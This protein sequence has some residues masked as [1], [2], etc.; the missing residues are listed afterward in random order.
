M[1]QMFIFFV[2]LIQSGASPLMI[3][4][5]C[6]ML[7]VVQALL[8]FH[9]RVDVFDEV[10]EAHFATKIIQNLSAMNK[11]FDFPVYMNHD[12]LSRIIKDS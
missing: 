11:Y 7:E 5:Q 4:S 12:N 10:V 2:C 9:A 1:I 8:R 3:A 6:G